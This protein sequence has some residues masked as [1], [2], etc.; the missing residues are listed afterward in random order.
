MLEGTLLALAA[1]EIVMDENAVLGPIDPQLG[2]YPAASILKVVET[3]DKNEIEDKTLI[4]ADVARKAIAQIAA[5]VQD[6]LEGKMEPE[7][8]QIVVKALTEGK[9][10]H[11]YPILIKQIREWGLPIRTDMPEEVYALMDLYP[12]P[13]QHRPSVQYIP[14]PY[15]RDGEPRPKGTP[16]R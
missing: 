4:L 14:I 1:D 6:I 10:T 9:W 5:F 2:E 3:K 16:S 15:R 13:T 7:Q 11:D 12:Q 8:T